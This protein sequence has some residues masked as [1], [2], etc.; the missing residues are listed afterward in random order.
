MRILVTG[1]AG[2]IGSRIARAYREAGHEVRGL[3]IAARAPTTYP[4]DI[5][6]AAYVS[7]ICRDFR[8]DVVSHHAAQISVTDSMR[9]PAE[10]AQTNIVGSLN[11]LRAAIECGAARFIF[12]SSAA[13]YGDIE[14]TSQHPIT[15]I[16]VPFP[17][18]PYGLA[19]L[20]VEKYLSFF[21]DTITPVILRYS[22]VYE[23][24][25]AGQGVY[26]QF[27]RTLQNNQP[28]IIRGDGS[29]TRDYVHVDDVARANVAALTRG[30]FET[31]NIS[32]GTET[33]TLQVFEQVKNFLGKPHAQPFFAD[34]SAGEVER[35][36]LSNAR[37]RHFGV[38]GAS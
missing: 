16:Y 9:D 1:A 29:A 38:L 18:N 4:G 2:F 15:E 19:K 14:A 8:P 25:A 32:T 17:A 5:R 6:H 23:M 7:A 13:V 36:V 27:Y 22:N 3:D 26:S 37:A 21:R 11:V 35:S 10:D 30:D 28:C 33:T 24:S 20:T 31:M 12:A 34:R